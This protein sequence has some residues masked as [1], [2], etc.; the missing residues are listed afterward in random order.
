[1]ITVIQN[2]VAEVHHTGNKMQL[3]N[4]T[5]DNRCLNRFHLELVLC[6]DELTCIGYEPIPEYQDP[7]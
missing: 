4:N 1:M 3:G 2:L 6:V 5:M 7:T